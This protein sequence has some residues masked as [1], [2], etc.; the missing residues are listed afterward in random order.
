MNKKNKQWLAFQ[1]RQW[2]KGADNFSSL[3]FRL[4]SKAQST[5]E[6]M[7]RLRIGF[8]DW[9]EIWEEW[10]NTQDETLFFKKYEVDYE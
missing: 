6:N 3:V 10:Q 9:V 8:L 7:A 2:Q 4:I 1:L 5:P